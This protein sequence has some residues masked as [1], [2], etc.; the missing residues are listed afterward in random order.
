[1]SEIIK[2][3]VGH[4]AHVTS[5]LMRESLV[6]KHIGPETSTNNELQ[7]LPDVNVI[8]LGGQSLLDRGRGTLLPLLDVIVECRKQYKLILGVGGGARIRHTYHICLDLGIPTGGLAM[9]A[10]GVDEQN[11][12]MLQSLLARHKGIALN[13]DHFLDLPLWLESGMIPIMTGMPP[14]HYWEPPTGKRRVPA[15]GQDMGIFMISEVL[16]A[17]SMIYLKDERGMY[18]DNPKTNPRAEFIP[19]I[20]ARELLNMR[21]PDMIIETAVLETMLNAR[22]TRQIQIVNGLQP[23]LLPR[24][25]AGEHVGTIIYATA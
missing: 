13:K 15:N 20:D 7:I 16:G 23:E 5:P 14:Y 1:M 25:L 12:R 11:T 22:H 3:G 9:V 18:T 2:E 10:G 8:S 24:A 17:R 6:G 21:L 19:K 4:R